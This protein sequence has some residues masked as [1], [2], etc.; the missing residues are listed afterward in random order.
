MRCFRV[1]SLA[2]VVAIAFT[3]S[4]PVS[5]QINGNGGNRQPQGP[6]TAQAS[7]QVRPPAQPQRA[8]SPPPGF[9]ITPD[10]QKWID[11]ILLYWQDSSA[12]VKTFSTSFT[13]WEYNPAFV[14]DPNT[15]WTEAA[16]VIRFAQPDKAMYRVDE[17]KYY[18]APARI[19]E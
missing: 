19:G 1:L 9:D 2:T 16:G 14:K 3:I 4:A 6:R 15:P 5:A 17:V 18:E 13:R 7:P 12:K 8:P 11:D 10:Q